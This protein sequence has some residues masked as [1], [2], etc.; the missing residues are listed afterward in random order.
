M[1][2]IFEFTRPFEGHFIAQ[3]GQLLD[4]PFGIVGLAEK[5]V[6]RDEIA[7]RRCVGRVAVDGL[8]EILD[9]RFETAKSR[10]PRDNPQ[11][12]APYS[13]GRRCGGRAAVG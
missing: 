2:D 11:P 9:R 7:V 8:Q 3:S 6:G 12:C 13:F 5:T 1:R 4:L 10:R